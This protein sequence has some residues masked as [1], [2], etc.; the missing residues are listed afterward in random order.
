MHPSDAVYHGVNVAGQ[1]RKDRR[2]PLKKAI[3]KTEQSALQSIEA[4][5][6]GC[7]MADQN[8]L[9]YCDHLYGFVEHETLKDG[10]V[11]KLPQGDPIVVEVLEP[12]NDEFGRRRVLG[13]KQKGGRDTLKIGDHLMRIASSLRVYR[14]TAEPAKAEPPK[15]DK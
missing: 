10:E 2:S 14:K 8:D 15:G 5:P 7:K 12:K 3:D 1:K 9:G 4:C 11:K 6:Y 13:H